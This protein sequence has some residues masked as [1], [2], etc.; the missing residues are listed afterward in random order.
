[1]VKIENFKIGK[2][3]LT[4][5]EMVFNGGLAAVCEIALV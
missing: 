1:M 4:P 3:M 2:N 5:N